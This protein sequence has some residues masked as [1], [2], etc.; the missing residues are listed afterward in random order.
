MKIL[1]GIPDLF[2]LAG[3][4]HVSLGLSEMFKDL[5]H[6]VKI[7]YSNIRSREEQYYVLEGI[8]RYYPIEVLKVPDFEKVEWNNYYIEVLARLGLYEDKPQYDLFLT[9][10]DPLA[11][12]NEDTRQKEV[13]Y[14]NW[15]A[16][17]RSPSCHVWANSK[18]TAHRILTKWNISS[19]VVNPPIK[20]ERYNPS[21]TF[22]ERD[23]D[24]IGF[25]Q[26]YFQKRFKAMTPLYQ[27]GWNTYII[28]AD[29]KQDT[30][31]VS[32]VVKNPDFREITALLSRS[33]IFVHPKIGEHFGMSIV[34]AM[35]SGCAIIC[36]RSGGPLTDIILPNETYGLLFSTEEELIKKVDYLLSDEEVWNHYSTLAVEGAERFSYEVIREKA[37]NELKRI[38]EEI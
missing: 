8:G 9:N 38:S 4:I 18:Y 12:I 5:G 17:P 10:F 3:N 36:H 34:E 14:V 16:R 25:G 24:V 23:I 37:D 32:Q 7:L 35:A 33:K 15:P 13:F 26:L 28:G 29:V 19:K 27:R 2:V 11:Y 31:T 1:V 30:P 22:S 6:E 20:L 21:P